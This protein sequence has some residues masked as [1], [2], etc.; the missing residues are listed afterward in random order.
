MLRIRIRDI[1]DPGTWIRDGK[2][3]INTA[4]YIS[5][6]PTSNQYLTHPHIALIPPAV[7]KPNCI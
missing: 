3:R 5:F 6:H 7:I 2:I 4:T 1:F